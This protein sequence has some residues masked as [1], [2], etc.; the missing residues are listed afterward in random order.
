MD[1][2]YG[3]EL[4]VAIAAVQRAADV[5][6]SVLAA[7][8]GFGAVQKEDLSPVTVADFAIQAILTASI[9][10]AFPSD[11]FVGEEDSTDLRGDDVLLDRVFQTI[12]QALDDGSD[13]GLA[14]GKALETRERVCELIDWCGNG[15]PLP[16][17]A[18][19]ATRVWV[20][21]P[22]D[23]TK[24]FIRGGL[25]A[26]NVALLEAGKQVLG[27][28]GLP[29]LSMD[30]KYPI[31]NSSVDPTGQG[32]ILFAVKSHGAYVRPLPGSVDSV[33][34]RRLPPHAETTSSLQH[35]RSV[36]CVEL[37]DS[38]ISDIHGAVAGRLGVEYPGCDLLGWVLRWAVLALGEAN[39]TV[40]LYHNRDRKARIWDHAGAMLLFEEVGGK[41]T[42]VDG[43]DVDLA[44]GRTLT[45]NYGFVAAP[46]A[47]HG[48][49]LKVVHDVM[50]ERGEAVLG[51][52]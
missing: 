32:S 9:H 15:V 40:W 19:G 46:R 29:L 51:S 13:E 24:T 20:F 14:L 7:S 23:G 43:K 52:D 30:A 11:K 31:S 49:V 18:D 48:A 35:L 25:Y 33:Q 27:V 5:S 28:V 37:M 26:I 44:A 45:A 36:T 16:P 39:M 6:R 1:S 41:I 2:P 17:G 42:D 10:A 8:E 12:R 47:L 34:P 21:D 3:A 4:R 50:R 38:G 22:I